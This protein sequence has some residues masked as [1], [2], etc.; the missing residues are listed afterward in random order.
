MSDRSCTPAKSRSDWCAEKCPECCFR[1]DF[2]SGGEL[3]DCLW[4][5]RLN[6]VPYIPE[7]SVQVDHL[8]AGWFRRPWSLICSFAWFGNRFG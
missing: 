1:A 3:P 5:L 2:C 7:F 8:V 6:G 4:V